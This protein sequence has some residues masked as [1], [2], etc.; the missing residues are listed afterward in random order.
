MKI[1]KTACLIILFLIALQTFSQRKIE[2]YIYEDTNLNKKK[3][4]TEKGIS[5][6]AVSNGK[7]VTITDHKG[8]YT[9]EIGDD[10][11]IFVIKPKGY[12]FPLD[13]Y[14][15]PQSYYIHKPEGSPLTK[16]EGVLPTGSLPL[17]LDFRM[18]K[19]DEPETFSTFIFGD[20]QVYSEQE[21]DFFEKGIVDE[22][23]ENPNP[24]FGI[25]LGDLVGND[26][27]LHP[28]YK[29]VIKQMD[30]T[31]YNVIGNHDL[32]FDAKNDSLSDETFERN[33]G[34]ATHS[35]NYGKAHFIVLDDVLYPNPNS[36]I[37]GA[38]LGGLREDQ[39]TFIEND[40]KY[41]DQDCLIIIATHI[42]F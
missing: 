27:S 19:Y 31:W 38:Y 30:R 26:L 3:D 40:L 34:P 12:K 8:K 18:I 28:S 13:E 17:S 36:A 1:K 14:N 41:V 39:F 7:D 25:T 21:V 24:V 42:P 20:S 15:M 11:I 6:V 32:N 35:F 2:G 33:F 10:N 4:R 29:K 9:L 16:Y 22:A 5:G 37:E 23:K